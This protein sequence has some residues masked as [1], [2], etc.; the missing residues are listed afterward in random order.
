MDQDFIKFLVCPVTKGPLQYA[1]ET[2]ELISFMAKLAYPVREGI[3]VLI[4]EEARSLEA[5]PPP[6]S[7]K[8]LKVK[9]A[10]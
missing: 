9:A 3:P 8:T 6:P 4:K 1:P 2:Q 7:Q 10:S 5:V